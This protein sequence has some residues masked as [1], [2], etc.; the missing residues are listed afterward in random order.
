LKFSLVFSLPFEAFKALDAD[1][2]GVVSKEDLKKKL[3]Q[4]ERKHGNDWKTKRLGNGNMGKSAM[5][6][7]MF[8]NR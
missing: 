3:L 5:E 6:N 2:D 4:A 7:A 8:S 1:G